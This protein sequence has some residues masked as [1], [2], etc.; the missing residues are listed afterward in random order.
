VLQ[1]GR[2]GRGEGVAEQGREDQKL[3]VYI[4]YTLVLIG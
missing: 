2:G 1:E 4:V 3:Y